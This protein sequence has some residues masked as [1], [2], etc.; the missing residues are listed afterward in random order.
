MGELLS[1]PSA[2]GFWDQYG[3]KIIYGFIAYMIFRFVLWV[4]PMPGRQIVVKK[5]AAPKK[6]GFQPREETDE[7]WVRL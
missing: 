7:S 1:S 5:A 6:E 3:T 4:W 2:S